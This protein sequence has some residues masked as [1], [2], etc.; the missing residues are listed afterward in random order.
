MIADLD[1]PSIFLVGAYMASTMLPNL[2]V[3]LP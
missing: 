3:L 2:G 1:Q